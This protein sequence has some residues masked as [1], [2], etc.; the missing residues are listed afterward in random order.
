M[1]VTDVHYRLAHLEVAH[2]RF[3][4]A[5]QRGIEKAIFIKTVCTLSMDADARNSE[6]VK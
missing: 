5:T 3:I 6:G 4:I 1:I 2:I